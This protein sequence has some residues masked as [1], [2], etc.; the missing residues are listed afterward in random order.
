MGES[1]IPS[2]ENS[3]RPLLRQKY[4]T[5]C[6]LITKTQ[7]TLKDFYR[8]EEVCYPFSPLFLTPPHRFV[9]NF[10]PC[11][12]HQPT[13][14]TAPTD[15]P[16]DYARP[17]RESLPSL[18]HPAPS[19]FIC[20]PC[21]SPRTT[22]Y[23]RVSFSRIAAVGL[24]LIEMASSF[25]RGSRGVGAFQSDGRV[26]QCRSF[27]PCQNSHRLHRPDIPIGAPRS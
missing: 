17:S 25:C 5:S 1:K 14:T 3:A 19:F 22:V 27:I 18:G 13:P 24:G 11:H 26:A 23:P 21:A 8:P 2:C 9:P 10:Q 4:P 20:S 12:F 7:T 15:C 16:R 6:H